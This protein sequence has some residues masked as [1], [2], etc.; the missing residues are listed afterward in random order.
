MLLLHSSSLPASSG[1]AVV[2]TALTILVTTQDTA[3]S[4]A[5]IACQTQLGISTLPQPLVSLLVAIGF[6]SELTKMELLLQTHVKSPTGTGSDPG[7]CQLRAA[8]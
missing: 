3:A 7:K 4:T 1:T 5:P 8:W 6:K 2:N